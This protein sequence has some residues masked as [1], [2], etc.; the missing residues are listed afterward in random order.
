MGI[1]GITGSK[2]VNGARIRQYGK[3]GGARSGEQAGL[4]STI[5]RTGWMIGWIKRRVNSLA[6]ESVIEPT[7]SEQL[8][9][10]ISAGTDLATLIKQGFRSID[11]IEVLG[12]L[13]TIDYLFRNVDNVQD[14]LNSQG[15]SNPAIISAGATDTGNS[16]Y[17]FSGFSIKRLLLQNDRV[18]ITQIALVLVSVRGTGI[19]GGDETVVKELSRSAQLKAGKEIYDLYNELSEYQ[20]NNAESLATAID[21]NSAG[22]LSSG[23]FGF[24]L[25]LIR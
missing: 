1:G 14:I 24:I 19:R 9:N 6:S 11:F 12:L 7:R 21:P 15:I 2:R 13:G 22:N 3:A 23:E 18:R 10:A 16:G 25:S 4:G 8:S 17:D 20:K 5:G